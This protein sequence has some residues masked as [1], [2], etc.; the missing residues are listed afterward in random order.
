MIALLF[1]TV[2]ALQETPPSAQ[3]QVDAVTI[4]AQRDR[5]APTVLDDKAIEDQLNDLLKKE[6]GRM[7]CLKKAPTGTRIARPLCGTLR[8]WYDF[9]AARNT[10][11]M[12]GGAGDMRGPP[13]E[14]VDLIKSRLANSKTRAMAEARAGA[15]LQAEA[16]AR[17]DAK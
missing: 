10:D 14:V 9:E 16:E 6:P 5:K 7:I 1:V 4:E 12:R 15:R 2:L 8:E 11:A 3:D 13:Y 17:A